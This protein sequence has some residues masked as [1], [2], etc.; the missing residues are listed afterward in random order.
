MTTRHLPETI[1]VYSDTALCD[2]SCAGEMTLYTDGI[3]AYA[4]RPDESDERILFLRDGVYVTTACPDENCH[5][6]YDWRLD[7]PNC[8]TTD[9]SARLML[10]YAEKMET[11]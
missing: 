10:G 4:I 6:H 5:G 8:W 7:S 3:I 2:G 11:A 1:A 9:P